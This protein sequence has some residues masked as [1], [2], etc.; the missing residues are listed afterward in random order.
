MIRLRSHCEWWPA[1]CHLLT[2]SSKGIWMRIGRVCVCSPRLATLTDGSGTHQTLSVWDL[3][4][5]WERWTVPTGWWC[6]ADGDM[7]AMHL[8]CLS[9][10]RRSDLRS[11]RK[12]WWENY[13]QEERG[14]ERLHVH[15]YVYSSKVRKDTPKIASVTSDEFDYLSF[16]SLSLHGLH[17]FFLQRVLT[18]FTI[19][20][21]DESISIWRKFS[22][23][24]MHLGTLA[25][26]PL[27][28]PEG[29]MEPVLRPL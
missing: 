17:F 4:G 5:I 23:K 21:N 12:M 2:T 15:I 27:A 13:I 26:L 18:N 7:F 3:C 14:K 1:T 16:S 28:K 19:S 11:G 24:G 22:L 8:P 9:M 6:Q 25:F 20:R 10:L 29:E